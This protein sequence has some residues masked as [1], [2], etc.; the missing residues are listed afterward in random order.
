MLLR[1]SGESQGDTPDLRAVNEGA[2]AAGGVSA[3]RALLAFTD[4]LIRPHEGDDLSR[5]RAELVRAVG[6]AGLVDAAAVAGNFE[7][8]NRIADSIGIPM[9]GPTGAVTLDV[10]EELGLRR[11]ASASHTPAPNTLQRLVGRFTRQILPLA[12]RWMS[13]RR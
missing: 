2:D 3:G 13:K 8:M 1:A 7:R 4:A 10:Q 9:D 5:A 12:A 6:E 11:F